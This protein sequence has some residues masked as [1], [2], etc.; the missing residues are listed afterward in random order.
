MGKGIGTTVN[1]RFSAEAGRIAHFLPWQSIGGTE[2]Q[3]LRLAEAAR[4]LGYFNVI[5][6]PEDGA[7]VR[8]LLEGGGFE[9]CEYN[10]VQPS[11]SKPRAFWRNLRAIASELRRKEINIVHCADIAAAHFMSLAGRLA[12]ATVISHVRNHYPEFAARDKS[13]LLPVQRFVF[14]SR[15]TRDSFG[16]KR[17][18]Q[19]S[20]VLYDVPGVVLK[21]L[22][23]RQAARKHFG[24]PADS[25]VFG[26]AARVSPQKDFPTL[27]HAARRVL[28][29]IPNCFFLIA[30][31]YELEAPHR[32]HFQ[33]LQPLLTQAGLQGRFCFAGFQ[34][35][36]SNFFGAI[37]AFVLSSNWEGLPTVV[38]EAVMYHK[39]VICTEVGGISEAIVDGMSGFLIPPK[40]PDVL[41]DRLLRVA[42]NP[43]LA[44]DMVASASRSLDQQFGPERFRAQVQGLYSELLSKNGTPVTYAPTAD[45]RI[46]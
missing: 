7:K 33:T 36:M 25:Y 26:M 6:V 34:A 32:E 5:Y 13:F 37:D 19:R 41:A 42:S 3:T 22:P 10:Q 46:R 18:R 17:A 24:L 20:R 45:P 38:L 40:S 39:P 16:I 28:A 4:E 29:E 43:A 11:Y 14:V 44:R 1:A 15:A 23:D 35:E 21:T 12:R 27:I 31:D 9:V 8:A 30:G 2:L